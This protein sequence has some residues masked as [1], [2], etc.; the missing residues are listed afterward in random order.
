MNQDI[1]E[2]EREKQIAEERTFAALKLQ[3]KQR[4]ETMIEKRKNNFQYLKTVHDGGTFWLNTVMIDKNKLFSLVSDTTR[5]PPIRSVMYYY[6]GLSL[7]KLLDLPP[8]PITVRAL[9]QL[10]EEWEYY[11]ASNTMQSMKYVMAR[12]SSYPYPQYM[13]NDGDIDQI[14]SGVYKFN[15]DIVY[16]HLQCPHV[17]FNLDYVQ[18]FYSLCEMLYELYDKFWHEDTFGYPFL[19][20]LPS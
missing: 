12:T 14:R 9:S 5:V 10:L 2:V 19:S 16:E 6:L 20:S 15:N 7:S 17:P 8:G 18:V 4:L 13:P 3:R 1:G 11:F